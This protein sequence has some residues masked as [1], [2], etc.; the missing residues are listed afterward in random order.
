MMKLGFLLLITF[1]CL[2][3]ALIPEGAMWF[4]WH[5]AAP[6]ME[7]S[8][9][10]LVVLFVTCGGGLSVLFGFLGLALWV[11]MVGALVDSRF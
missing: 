11:A 8:R 10:L 9:L 6:T 5:V 3:F 2:V 4:I 1:V 7:V